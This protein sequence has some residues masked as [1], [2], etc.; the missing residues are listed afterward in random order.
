VGYTGDGPE[1]IEASDGTRFLLKGRSATANNLLALS[2]WMNKD[3]CPL[4]AV[5]HIPINKKI[6]SVRLLM[7]NYVSPIKNYIPNGEVVLHY[8]DGTSEITQLIPPYNLD[9]YFQAFSREGES[10][11]LG[12]LEEPEGWSPCYKDMDSAQAQMLPIAC[13]PSRTLKEIEIRATVSEGVLGI[14]AITLIPAE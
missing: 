11:P 13:D 14:T 2:S 10:I 1:T 8:A 7:Q 9:C 12:G 4:P 5:A 6:K 3:A